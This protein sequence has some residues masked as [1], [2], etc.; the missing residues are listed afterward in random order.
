MLEPDISVL[1]G[2]DAKSMMLNHPTSK[3]V[4]LLV[5]V[6]LSSLNIDRELKYQIYVE[7]DILEF[8]IVDL[9]HFVVHVYKQPNKESRLYENVQTYTR[10][11]RIRTLSV[12]VSIDDFFL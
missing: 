10:G 9:V 5:E 12:E 7:H 8:W 6:A 4:R 3:N 2:Y 11:Q 1:E